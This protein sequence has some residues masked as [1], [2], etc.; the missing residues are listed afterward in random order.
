MNSL[1]ERTV[2]LLLA[3]LSLAGCSEF[4]CEAEATSHYIAPVT[5]SYAERARYTYWFEDGAQRVTFDRDQIPITA[6]GA[7]LVHVENKTSG[8]LHGATG[9]AADVTDDL[10]S[11]AAY[12]PMA[13]PRAAA[14]SAWSGSWMSS[15]VATRTGV[16]V[17][18]I[19]AGAVTQDALD[20][21]NN[22]ESNALD[23]EVL[24]AT[25]KAGGKEDRVDKAPD[26]PNAPPDLR[27]ELQRQG[28]SLDSLKLGRAL[29]VVAARQPLPRDFGLS[30]DVH[31][32]WVF[33]SQDC[34]ACVEAL[35]WLDQ[36]GHRYHAMLVS[37]P[38]NAKTLRAL[39]TRAGVDQAAV[40][41][42]WKHGSLIRGFDT[43]LWSQEMK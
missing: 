14:F 15:W 43:K 37:D 25:L 18:E 2:T 42:L 22:P 23:P 38:T 8:G 31:P 36:S 30:L 12:V 39:S 35:D 6:R 28:I 4:P 33:V 7:V 9:W 34:E 20:E 1:S 27:K 21:A 11:R 5:F 24:L 13:V 41:T 10:G 3:A 29:R 32:T 19:A 26:N 17:E 40:P 16:L